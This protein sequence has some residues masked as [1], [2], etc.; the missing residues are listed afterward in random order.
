MKSALSLAERFWSFVDKADGCWLWRGTR[1][2]NG[3][4]GF[5]YGLKRVGASRMAWELT[6][7]NIPAGMLV[8]HHCDIPLCCNPAHLFLGSQR[9]NQRD[10]SRKGRCGKQLPKEKVEHALALLSAGATYSE[11]MA[12]LRIS[13]GSISNIKNRR[14]GFARP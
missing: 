4:G 12:K 5:S 1:R 14:Q 7:G 8:C 10:A 3:Y 6:H 11:I 9:D 13:T 2:S